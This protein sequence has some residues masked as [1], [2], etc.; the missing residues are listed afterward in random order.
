MEVATQTNPL[1]T[2][3]TGSEFSITS[4][5]SSFL[6]PDPYTLLVADIRYIISGLALNKLTV[7]RSLFVSTCKPLGPKVLDRLVEPLKKG[8]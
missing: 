2:L 4:I 7:S 1:K 8:S 5:P 3:P 6:S